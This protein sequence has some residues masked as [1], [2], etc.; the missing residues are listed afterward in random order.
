MQCDRCNQRPATVHL[1][2]IT[3]GQ[4]QET[5]LCEVCAKEI[6]LQGFGFLPQMNL[7]KF[8]AGLLNYDLNENNFGHQEAGDPAR[9]N[10]LLTPIVGPGEN[11]DWF[12]QRAKPVA[13]VALPL[14]P[15]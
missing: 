12:G 1:T 8:L 3:N 2:E 10:H 11:A 5:H 14:L 6:Q 15:V 4:K 13:Q 7:H 9:M